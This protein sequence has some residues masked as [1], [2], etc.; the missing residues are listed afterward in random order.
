MS[1]PASFR[2][3]ASNAAFTKAGSQAPALGVMRTTWPF[4]SRGH[5]AVIAR[6][7]TMET[8]RKRLRQRAREGSARG[9]WTS[10]WSGYSRGRANH[11]I[12]NRRFRAGLQIGGGTREI[13]LVFFLIQLFAKFLRQ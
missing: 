4:S 6:N 12:A 3:E 1:S 13:L 10:W 2:S 11:S 8:S 9:I 7:A 5:S